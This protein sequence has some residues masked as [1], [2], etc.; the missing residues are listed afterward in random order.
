MPA[1][2][3]NTS[4]DKAPMCDPSTLTFEDL[5]KEFEH[6]AHEDSSS[7]A[8]P[9]PQGSPSFSDVE[10]VVPDPVSHS[11]ALAMLDKLQHYFIKVP[12][13]KKSIA[14]LRSLA[15]KA[16]KAGLRQTTLNF[17]PQTK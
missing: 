10:E 13:A 17:A 15:V 6:Q 11:E 12:E 16:R 7:S 8:P 9:P 4:I 14:E 2:E 3:Y 5:W 1:D